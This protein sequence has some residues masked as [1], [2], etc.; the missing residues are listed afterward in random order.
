MPQD[1]IT[2]WTRHNYLSKG[3]EQGA[4]HL[5]QKIE[6]NEK[7]TIRAFKVR[8]TIMS[9]SK[10]SLS[11]KQRETLKALEELIRPLTDEEVLGDKALALLEDLKPL[12]EQDICHEEEE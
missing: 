10:L 1:I 11:D 9:V 6:E 8:L 2:D 4:R 12:I 7:H 3:G 5:K